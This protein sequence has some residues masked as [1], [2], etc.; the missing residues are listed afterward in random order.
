MSAEQVCSAGCAGRVCSGLLSLA[1]GR[2]SSPCVS[3]SSSPTHISVARASPFGEDTR[4]LA[5]GPTLMTSV[6]GS[7]QSFVEII[8]QYLCIRILN[9][10]V[11]HL[12]LMRCCMSIISQL[13]IYTCLPQ[14]WHVVGPLGGRLVSVSPFLLPPDFRLP[15]SGPLL[16]CLRCTCFRGRL[17][18]ILCEKS[19]FPDSK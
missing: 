8:L 2:L 12:K 7:L 1:F 3:T 18:Q 11:I 16:L 13:K 6:Q 17:S 10:Y 19:C 9:H 4:H 14:V 15:T 5:L